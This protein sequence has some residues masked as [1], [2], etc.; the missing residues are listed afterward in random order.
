MIRY[1]QVVSGKTFC[2]LQTSMIFLFR[3]L[4]QPFNLLATS[5][6]TWDQ[7][8]LSSL[9]NQRLDQKH[10]FAYKKNV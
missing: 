9:S 10:W 3:T 7:R 4:Q 5:E 8:W 6:A 1:I 2:N